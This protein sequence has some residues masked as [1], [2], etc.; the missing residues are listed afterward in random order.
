MTDWESGHVAA[1]GL[2]LHYTRTGGDKPPLVMAHG[3]TDDG[4]CWAPVAEALAND[5]DVIMV[6][7]RG[8]GRSD[9]GP[10][11]YGPGVQ[12]A[13]LAGVIAALGLDKPAVLGHS[14]G[15]ATA[16]AL[17]GTY[18]NVPGAI[19]L[20]DPPAWWT[21][22][23]D[24]PDGAERRTRMR[25]DF[26]A[27]KRVTRAELLA[28]KRAEEPGW[29]DAEL[30]R[31]VDAKQRYSLDV[32]RVLD[33]DNPNDVDW[34]AVLPRITCPAL[35]IVSD[36][37]RGGIITDESAAALRELVPHVEIVHVPEAGHSIRRDQ[38]ARYVEVVR[39]FLTQRWQQAAA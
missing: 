7:A 9:E 19:L 38:F 21:A 33:R 13:D 31:W 2:R 8:H 29:S 35:L 16:L 34:P 28:A 4:L 37:E 15:A 6:D 11:G 14:M 3:V 36:P 12:A 17:A 32:L 30:E 24:S 20:E 27:Q 26:T 18:P 5:Y 10:D 22:W 23:Y 39:D 25:A 1:N